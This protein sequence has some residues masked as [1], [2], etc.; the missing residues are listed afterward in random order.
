MGNEAG[1]P[2]AGRSGA[3]V[4]ATER[5]TR[6]EPRKS[7]SV[8]TAPPRAGETRAPRRSPSPPRPLRLLSGRKS[9]GAPHWT[10]RLRGQS[11]ERRGGPSGQWV[12]RQK[13]GGPRLREGSGNAGGAGSQPPGRP[14][15][16]PPPPPCPTPAGSAGRPPPALRG[17]RPGPR[18]VTSAPQPPAAVAA[19]ARISLYHARAR[20][21]R[22]VRLRSRETWAGLAETLRAG[23][24]TE[25]GGPVSVPRPGCRGSEN[26]RNQRPARGT[27]SVPLCAAGQ[28]S[29]GRPSR[30]LVWKSTAQRWPPGAK[31]S[32]SPD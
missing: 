32:C 22:D 18:P 9:W 2:H 15:G 11:T 27:T 31:L 23:A 6:E 1:A 19:A 5:S 8:C 12:R 14:G 10:P 17:A 7:P 29:T 4:Q 25:A 30:S 24:L 3:G 21:S 20:A 13:P 16:R 28:A 26:A